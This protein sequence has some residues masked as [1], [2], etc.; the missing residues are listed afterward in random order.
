MGRTIIY[1]ELSSSVSD[2]S[3]RLRSKNCQFWNVPTT[4]LPLVLLHHLYVRTQIKLLREQ[5][6]R[7]IFGHKLCPC[8]QIKEDKMGG[9]YDT[10]YTEKRLKQ[11]YL[12]NLMGRDHFGIKLKWVLNMGWTAFNCLGKG[13]NG[14]CEVWASGSVKGWE[15]IKCVRDLLS[16]IPASRLLRK[17]FIILDEGGIFG[18]S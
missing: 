5:S 9:T 14:W 13:H 10:C 17:L 2:V 8:H 15:L 7:R 18:G 12:G 1:A 3:S 11:F 6:A 4:A 16:V